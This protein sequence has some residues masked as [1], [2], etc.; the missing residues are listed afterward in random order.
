MLER[1]FPRELAVVGVHSGKSIAERERARITRA[2]ARLGVTHPVVN[3]RQLRTWRAWAVRAWP[4]IA[5]GDPRGYVVGVQAGELTAAQLA[6]VIERL[7]AEAEADGTLVRAAPHA[8][9]EPRALPDHALRFPGKV[10]VSAPDARGV[11]RLA[12]ADTGRHRL[13]IG[14][15]DA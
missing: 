14:R 11:R 15:L 6:P 2:C 3:D 9:A 12:I 10:A 1:R 4:T 7:I 5:L 8:H 13:V